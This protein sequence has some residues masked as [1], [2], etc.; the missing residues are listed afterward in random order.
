VL[1][2]AVTEEEQIEGLAG[3][4]STG[5][6]TPRQ[7]RAGKKANLGAGKRGGRIVEGS[8][9]GSTLCSWAFWASLQ[10]LWKIVVHLLSPWMSWIG[11]ASV[12]LL[13]LLERA[14]LSLT[15]AF[16]FFYSKKGLHSISKILVCGL[17]I[18]LNYEVGLLARFLFF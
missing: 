2:Q 14:S 18:I 16:F 8:F 11:V 15:E 10:C 9:G 3:L 1:N 12:A 7:R 5:V 6:R 4:K 13:G 17:F